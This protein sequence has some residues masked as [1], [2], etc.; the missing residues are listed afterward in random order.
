M[1]SRV[2]S[3]YLISGSSNSEEAY[4]AY[5]PE[6][7]GDAWGW[8]ARTPAKAQWLVFDA[9]A[10][11]QVPPVC[12]FF[13]WAKGASE[14][15]VRVQVASAKNDRWETQARTTVI[16]RSSEKA[17]QT[18]HVALL[19]QG[20]T[21]QCRYI[22]VL[23]T[24]G[25]PFTLGV[26]R[27]QLP[28]DEF[29]EPLPAY[30]IPEGA[31]RVESD[32][33]DCSGLLS[34]DPLQ[35]WS[36]STTQLPIRAVF[37][38][39]GPRARASCVALQMGQPDGPA[40]ARGPREIRVH[41]S[42]D[43]VRWS[44]VL[45]RACALWNRG[46]RRTFP[47]VWEP[48]VCLTPRY[49]RL[50]I[51]DLPVNRKGRFELC[52][53]QWFPVWD[54][55]ESAL[56][57]LSPVAVD[58]V[59]PETCDVTTEQLQSLVG[60]TPP[61]DPDCAHGPP[62]AVVVDGSLTLELDSGRLASSAVAL[63]LV[64]EQ[65]A[66]FCDGLDDSSGCD[67]DDHADGAASCC[68]HEA[69]TSQASDHDARPSSPSSSCSRSAI[70]SHGRCGPPCGGEP[71]VV[72]QASVA[73]GCWDCVA[74]E[75][76]DF[77]PGMT[78]TIALRNQDARYFRVTVRGAKIRLIS[79][80]VLHAKERLP[81]D[82][83]RFLSMDLPALLKLTETHQ[84]MHSTPIAVLLLCLYSLSTSKADFISS[85]HD[86]MHQGI[87]F[88]DGKKTCMFGKLPDYPCGGKP[89]LPTDPPPCDAAP[90]CPSDGLQAR[91]QHKTPP[92]S[93]VPLAKRLQK[94]DYLLQLDLPHR[95]PFSTHGRAPPCCD[96]P[97]PPHH[98]GDE[99]GCLP[100]LPPH[101]DGAK[102]HRHHHPREPGRGEHCAPPKDHASTSGAHAKDDHAMWEHAASMQARLH[103]KLSSI[104]G[105]DS[106]H[107]TPNSSGGNT[108]EEV[109]T[110]LQTML[111]P[112]QNP[113][114]EGPTVHASSSCDM[115]A[116]H[117]S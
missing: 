14:V 20:K 8:A 114:S 102:H 1:C 67:D 70:T 31:M 91:L 48:H 103:E 78:H 64:V 108:S 4:R 66:N 3:A 104:L 68:S 112:S 61:L 13:L 43:G 34:A 36:M 35:A 24:G 38:A 23:F 65:R 18:H 76:V 111:D 88:S 109:H 95:P 50:E 110:K 72:V 69:V 28:Q 47:L 96:D 12:E 46:E 33:C 107:P 55:D 117:W 19:L 39:L 101:A 80:Q 2:C 44:C 30:S 6:S 29:L 105:T 42:E 81:P 21:R 115:N 82:H 89:G 45:D 52:L 40:A 27:L 26:R 92:C 22:K 98:K 73:T 86:I 11:T 25:T 106:H 56:V 49:Y 85:L 62:Q 17:M 63:R 7:P 75:R 84:D 94:F 32:D 58:V 97:G 93:D 71:T 60:A 16:F 37:D 51:S 79:L 100:P 5:L 41:V 87:A 53:A 83:Q 74:Q 99:R 113:A 9:C 77:V 59:S 90:H 54:G 116:I 57:P 15:T 10:K